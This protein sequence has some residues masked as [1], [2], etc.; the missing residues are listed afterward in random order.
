[1]A[2]PSGLLPTFLQKDGQLVSGPEQPFVGSGPL[3]P[4]LLYPW[5]GIMANFV[6]VQGSDQGTNYGWWEGG[7]QQKAQEAIAKSQVLT[8]HSV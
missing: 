2:A 3:D 7:G 1:M 8:P 6:C 4:V 5:A